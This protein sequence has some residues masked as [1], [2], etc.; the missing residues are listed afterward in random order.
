MANRE[1]N[2]MLCKAFSVIKER[3]GPINGLVLMKDGKELYFN[4]WTDV[5]GDIE[6]LL[7]A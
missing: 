1:D 7:C 3:V 2:E 4:A 5:F 6:K